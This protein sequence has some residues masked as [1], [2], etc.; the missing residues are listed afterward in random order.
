MPDISA[1]PWEQVLAFREH[2]GSQEARSELREFE[3]LAEA[4]GPED[5]GEYLIRVGHNVVSAYSAT[6][7]ELRPKLG[8]EV[9]RQ[10][11][12]LAVGI[13]PYAG[14]ALGAVVGLAD[15][16]AQQRTFSRSATAALMCLEP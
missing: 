9:A 16:A 1:V 14:Q 13:V 4:E 11:S 10:N 8:D 15:V 3:R 12:S 6:V 2:G 5:A 7:E